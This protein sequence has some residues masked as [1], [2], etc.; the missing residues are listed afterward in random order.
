MA[1]LSMLLEFAPGLVADVVAVYNAGLGEFLHFCFVLPAQ[2]F[3]L[4]FSHVLALYNC[5]MWIVNGVFLQVLAPS[6][7][8]DWGSVGH[9][10]RF[11]MSLFEFSK[12]MT[13]S[14]ASWLMNVMSC[15]TNPLGGL[16]VGGAGSP[17]V[18]NVTG[19]IECFE[20]GLVNLDLITPSA[21]LR[22][23]CLYAARFVTFTCPSINALLDLVTFPL[24][25]INLYKA[26]HCLVNAALNL[27]VQTPYVTLYRCRRGME[28]QMPDVQRRILCTPD[29]KPSIDLLVA[30]LRFLGQA[31]D[32]WMDISLVILQTLFTG[33]APECAPVPIQLSYENAD[34]VAL[35]GG[36]YRAVVGL[37]PGMY[38]VTDGR[39]TEYHVFYKQ[40]TREIAYQNWPF[41]VE[42]MYGIAAVRYGQ[43]PETD[44]AGGMTTGML[45]CECL[46]VE[47]VGAQITCAIVPYLSGASMPASEGGVAGMLKD[48]VVGGSGAMMA[49]NSSNATQKIPV[50]FSIPSSSR[51][52]TCKRLK[53]E[54]RS[55]RWPVT[56]VSAS[57]TSRTSWNQNLGAAQANL[58]Q[59]VERVGADAV[60]YVMPQCAYSA[61]PA[62][63]CIPDF[64]GFSCY[65]YCMGVHLTGSVNQ[66]IVLYGANDWRDSVQYILRD[67][68]LAQS[69]TG[70]ALSV[71]GAQAAG[72]AARYSVD[73]A[74][75]F[76]V[77]SQASWDPA[78]QSCASSAAVS[79][80]LH[81][82]LTASYVFSADESTPT[83]REAA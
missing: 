74:V 18:L 34:A 43:L 12:L 77:A 36:N 82:N 70:E 1:G 57:A 56:R 78:T 23:V 10:P 29:F 9:L 46:D 80:R 40:V 76:G 58:Q 69:T 24:S 38:A 47:G 41:P 51:H 49:A 54:V 6:F 73:G 2:M 45:G 59:V 3:E 26:L 53:I 22:D 67:C 68:G 25:D 65:P 4:L 48:F 66:G 19:S 31:V 15:A 55:L 72:N 79:S 8:S 16:A 39:S 83:I 11:C 44:T 62:P 60:I 28:L 61:V 71:E 81:V 20:P 50:S 37:T 35:F 52:V 42:P 64:T 7:L 30:G 33:S 21:S 5:A 27:F 14:A 13:L 17:L 63:A 32:N 75:L